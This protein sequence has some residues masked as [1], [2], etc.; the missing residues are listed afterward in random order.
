M[1]LEGWELELLETWPVSGREH[2]GSGK[3]REKGIFV[4]GFP[5]G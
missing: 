2:V 5:S 4:F 3:R 1:L